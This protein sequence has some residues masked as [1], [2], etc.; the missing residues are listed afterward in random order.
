MKKT[1]KKEKHSPHSPNRKW[2]ARGAYAP[3][4]QRVRECV[5][6]S[7]RHETAET[8]AVPEEPDRDF[9][10]SANVLMIREGAAGVS[11]DYSPARNLSD[12]S[13]ICNCAAIT[14]TI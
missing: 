13:F 1:R 2:R 7:A 9:P 5:S 4:F 14:S 10:A 12:G 3:K 8:E 11:S 6:A